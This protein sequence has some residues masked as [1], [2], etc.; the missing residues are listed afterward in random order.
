MLASRGEHETAA[1]C[2]GPSLLAS[3]LPGWG[4]RNGRPSFRAGPTADAYPFPAV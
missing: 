3:T 4:P 1:C 2:V